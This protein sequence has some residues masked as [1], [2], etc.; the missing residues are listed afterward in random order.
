VRKGGYLHV[1]P[2][3]LE[4]KAATTSFPVVD[5][6]N[7]GILEDWIISKSVQVLFQLM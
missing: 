6:L 1:F 4:G 7:E 5:L 3:T 2:V